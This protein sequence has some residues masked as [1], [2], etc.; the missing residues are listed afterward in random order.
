MARH[1]AVTVRFA[2]F[3][4]KQSQLATLK[5]GNHCHFLSPFFFPSGL[6]IRVLYLVVVKQVLLNDESAHWP[7]LAK[8]SC[9]RLDYI[10]RIAL[11]HFCSGAF[12]SS[13]FPIR[14]PS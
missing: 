7:H 3:V 2:C 1:V 13:R 10:V 11:T 5:I 9:R 8:R 14:H 6:L 12:A 4:G